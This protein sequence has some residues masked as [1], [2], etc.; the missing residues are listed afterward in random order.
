MLGTY[1]FTG[2]FGLLAGPALTGLLYQHAGRA[3]AM[4][5]T[6]GVLGACAV[7]TGVLVPGRRPQTS[8]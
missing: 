1:R 6:A 3:S 7:A 4:L 8:A 2:D 5:V